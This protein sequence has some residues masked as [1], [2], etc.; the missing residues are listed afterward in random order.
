MGSAPCPA[1][2]ARELVS[3]DRSESSCTEIN[4]PT[5]ENRISPSLLQLQDVHYFNY[6]DPDA[7]DLK[8]IPMESCKQACLRNCTCKAALFLFYYNITHG[9]CFLPSQVLSLINLTG[10]CSKLTKMAWYNPA[11]ST[12][13]STWRSYNPHHGSD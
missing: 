3:D 6:V 8:G 11:R 7:A 2:F 10:H 9:N 12:L 4:P 5:C 13:L 1:G